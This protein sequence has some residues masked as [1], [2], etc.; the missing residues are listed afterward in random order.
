MTL[1]Y[2]TQQIKPSTT[3]R[4]DALAKQLQHEGKN[5]INLSAGEPDFD[6]PAPIKEAAIKAVR[7]GKTKYTAVGGI[8]ALK[9]AII[10]KFET[11]NQLQY[12][13]QEVMAS[14][15]CKQTIYNALLALINPDDEVIIP[16]PYWVSYPEMV[17]L[18]QGKPTFIETSI[19][20]HFK[21]TADQLAEKITP[22]TK[23]LFLNSP[24]NPSGMMYTEKELKTLAEVLLRHPQI[25]IISDD[26]Y[27][28]IH[29]STS[30]FKN[31]INVC[32]A[33]KSRTIICHGV[34]KTYAMTGFRIGYAAATA[35]IITAMSN[36]QSQSTS[37]PNSIGQYAAVEALIGNQDC[38]KKMTV[39]YHQRHTLLYKGLNALQGFQCAPADGAFYSFPDISEA[40]K[41]KKITS[42]VDFCTYLLNETGLAVVPGSAFGAPHNIRFSY[43]V[44]EKVIDEALQRLQKVFGVKDSSL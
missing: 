5:I 10:Q 1:S 24:S 9:Q 26:I 33:L 4:I 18:V 39:I 2:R 41:N 7:E 19:A 17:L 31:I 20:S 42:D 23:A 6:T 40:M 14:N 44:D 36:F 21:I 25:Y 16:V 27:E 43:A 22:K 38:V 34:S 15:G 28:H 32:P 8:P 12:S 35:E 37:N 3:M 13:L 29:W 30:P 11:E